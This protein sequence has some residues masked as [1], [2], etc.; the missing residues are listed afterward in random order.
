MYSRPASGELAGP[1]AVL[2]ELDDAGDAPVE[3]GPV[4]RHHHHRTGDA[5]D[6][7]LE[8]VEPGEVEVVGGLVEQQHVVARQQDRGQRGPGRLP[9]RQRGDMAWSR[10]GSPAT[11]AP[12]EEPDRGADLRG[13]H[14]DVVAP[15]GEEAVERIGVGIERIGVG[16][17]RLGAAGRARGRLGDPGAPAR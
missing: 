4:V 9:A 12:V 1:V 10:R 11:P 7:G 2:V 15:E 6:E 13:P 5:V 8:L 3:E 14:L 16:G 17:Q